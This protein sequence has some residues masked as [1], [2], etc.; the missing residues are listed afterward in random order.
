MQQSTIDNVK[1][2]QQHNSN[3]KADGLPSSPNNGNTLVGC[4][5]GK[6]Q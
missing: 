3:S 1:L 2:E 6:I 5:G 4:Q